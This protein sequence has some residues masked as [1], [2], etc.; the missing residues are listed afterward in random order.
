MYENPG[1]TWPPAA[2]AHGRAPSG[3]SYM[4]RYSSYRLNSAI[5][6]YL[7]AI[8]RPFF[9]CSSPPGNASAYALVNVS[10]H[11]LNNV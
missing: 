4:Y 6:Q 9:R 11:V 8:F 5:F 3:F 1:G 7:F 10:F 2:D